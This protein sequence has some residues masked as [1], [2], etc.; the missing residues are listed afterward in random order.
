[1]K[2]CV[3]HTSPQCLLQ[4]ILEAQRVIDNIIAANVDTIKR[5]EQEMN[6][7]KRNQPKQKAPKDTNDKEINASVVKSVKKRCRYFN[8][9]F[10]KYTT[11]C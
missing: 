9:G 1:M 2:T 10:C 5:I 3:L 4:D 6:E 11:K 7:L 8:T